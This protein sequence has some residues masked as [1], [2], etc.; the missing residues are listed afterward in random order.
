MTINHKPWW[1]EPLRVLDIVYC[2]Q[3]A[4]M[5]YEQL[6]RWCREFHAN[7]IHFHFHRETRGG[8]A[9]DEVY[10]RSRVATRQNRDVLAE[11]LPVAK[12]CGVRVVLYVNG[13][14]FTK[15]FVDQ[16]PD[17]RVLREDGSRVENL[18]GDDDSTFCINSPW[19]DWMRT[20]I[21][22][23]CQY[24]IDGLFWDGPLYF[25]HRQGC[26]CHWCRE[27][28]RRAFGKEMPS[29]D[30]KKLED[31]ELLAE[32]AVSSLTG[33]Y[34]DAYG[35]VKSLKPEA[36]VYMNAA[37]V[38]EPA[39]LVGRDNRRLLPYTDILL[40][41]G[42]FGKGRLAYAPSWKT[43]ASSKFY[44]MQAAGKPAVNAVTSANSPWRR[45]QLSGGEMRVLLAQA[46][47]GVS[48][49][50]AFFVEGLGQSGDKASAEVYAFLEKN[51]AALAGTRSLARVALLTSTRTLDRYAGVDI[52][53]TDISGIDDR[54]AQTAGN[55]SASFYGHYEMLVRARVPFDVLDDH[56]IETGRL[57][58]YEL[59]VLPTAAC[60]T[61][62]ECAAIRQFVQEG[63][64]LIADFETSHY[65]AHGRR[66]RDLALAETFG[67]SSLNRVAGPRRWDFAKVSAPCAALDRIGA[68]FVPATQHQLQVS[69]RGGTTRMVFSL[70][71]VSNIPDAVEFTDEPFLVEHAWGKGRS[72]YFP[73][74]FGEMFQAH[75][76]PAYARIIS[77]ILARETTPLVRI[78]NL[79]NL[80]EVSLRGCPGHTLVHLVNCELGGIEEASPATD[81]T[82]S[83]VVPYN[84][85]RVCALRMEK[86]LA[87]HQK[88]QEATFCLPRLEAFEVVS[89]EGETTAQ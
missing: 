39:W 74:T 7:V 28:F 44:E 23:F 51:T 84:V 56:A 30:R 45:C 69:L 73:G 16:H 5:D 82:V 67:V 70:P 65:D 12:R 86:D 14:W 34:R 41:E 42:G 3:V 71:L 64:R 81:V 10:C 35:W 49:Y 8:F 36:A 20:R 57:A 62:N 50:A 2:P 83:I 6:G 46:S 55:H 9:P 85:R 24:D 1:A 78:G 54:K 75:R 88:G 32:F 63:G 40:A 60:L 18:Y 80:V 79:A 61:D 52:P 77:G 37:N 33:Y 26:Y 87:F 19:R 25:L 17:W 58:Q 68:P 66:R 47:C 27:K 15:G 48:P 13:H 76:F 43:S 29:W 72:F 22:D 31:W 21:E 89:I 53:W 38:A 4:E 11:F 59:L